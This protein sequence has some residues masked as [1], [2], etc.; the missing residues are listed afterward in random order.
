MT[1]KT[2][3]DF[4]ALRYPPEAKAVLLHLAR[5]G[6]GEKSIVELADA[7][8]MTRAMVDRAGR[9]LARQKVNPC[10]AFD[11]VGLDPDSPWCAVFK[12]PGRK[13]AT[14]DE[15]HALKILVMELRS[16][17]EDARV[18][19]DRLSRLQDQLL[20]TEALLKSVSDE[21]DAYRARVAAMS[22]MEGR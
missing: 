18:E 10:P 13:S 9:F 2:L 17:L 12:K 15:A 21:R 7:L 8:G 4:E 20:R 5:H 11:R 6:G 14:D 1:A 19:I 22:G 16:K 3:E